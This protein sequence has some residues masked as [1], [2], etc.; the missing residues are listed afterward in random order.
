VFLVHESAPPQT[1]INNSV[2]KFVI[3]NIQVVTNSNAPFLHLLFDHILFI[4][5]FA[6]FFGIS[7]LCIKVNEI[8]PVANQQYTME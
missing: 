1:R 7:S 6:L 5:I 8:R 2:D 4:D 3:D